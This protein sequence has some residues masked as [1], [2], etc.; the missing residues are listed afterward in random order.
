M[1][2]PAPLARDRN[3]LYLDL[4]HTNFT[5]HEVLCMA[6]TTLGSKVIGFQYY[7]AQ[8]AV[9]LAFATG[10]DWAEW[11]NKELPDLNMILY[12]QHSAPVFLQ[13]LTI[14]GC[15]TDCPNLITQQIKKVFSDYG[16]VA[17]VVPMV[18]TETGW[19]SDSWQVTLRVPSAT[20][21]LPPVQLLLLEN[22]APVTVNAPGRRFC[23]YC[24]SHEHIKF[25]CRQGQRARAA[26]RRLK[27]Q[28]LAFHQERAQELA[29][30][31]AA[32]LSGDGASEGVLQPADVRSSLDNSKRSPPL[33]PTDKSHDNDGDVNMDGSDAVLPSLQTYRTQLSASGSGNTFSVLSSND[34]SLAH[35][36]GA[37]D[38]AFQ[39]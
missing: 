18:M 35:G 23:N 6:H 38:R 27:S 36:Q 22:E 15:P 24:E 28:E 4:R 33:R 17:A 37:A 30:A 14:Q 34:G 11:K 12:P 10:S 26:A 5:P 13:R 19:H 25:E 29:D 3:V 32:A 8:K 39:E 1:E 16:E 9:S 2:R 21:P 31:A 20:S 7:A